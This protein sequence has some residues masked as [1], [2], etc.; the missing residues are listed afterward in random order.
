[1]RSPEARP[2]RDQSPGT[3]P[4]E[5]SP[6]SLHTMTRWTVRPA[7]PAPRPRTGYMATDLPNTML[8]ARY[9]T[10]GLDAGTIRVEA[11]DRPNPHPGEV[12]VAVAVSGVNPADW[13]A[14]ATL[15]TRDQSSSSAD[16]IG[17]VM[18]RPG[19]G[20]GIGPP[21]LAPPGRA[22]RRNTATVAGW[23]WRCDGDGSS[24]VDRDCAG[25]K[26]DGLWNSP[27]RFMLAAAGRFWCPRPVGAFRIL[28]RQVG[29]PR[30]RAP[31]AK[32]EQPRPYASTKSQNGHRRS[33]LPPV[34]EVRESPQ[35]WLGC[36]AQSQ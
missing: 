30:R 36:A 32:R 4:S 23:T 25:G 26:P 28:G 5:G 2:T 33:F 6:A 29:R 11:V 8:A 20:R 18:R 1:M 21:A 19:P 22:R 14:R 15:A 9:P 16:V 3:Q 34:R 31:A 24:E 10:N 35:I 7:P 13:K 27:G 17:A 12:L